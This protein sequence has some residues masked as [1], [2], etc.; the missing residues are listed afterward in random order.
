[1]SVA[2]VVVLVAAVMACVGAVLVL[3][4]AVVLVGAVRRL[5]RGV[6]A[7]RTEA[8]P[9]V[10]GARQA[11]DQA[12]DEMARVGAVLEST[13]SV[14]ATVDSV[15]RLAQRAF[16]NPVVKI[17][18]FRA[19]AATGLRQLRTPGPRV[20]EPPAHPRRHRRAG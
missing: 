14:T 9:L 6:E 3:V 5:E 1:M 19:G 17:L 15:S 10:T 8:V 11:V 2:D 16:T 4:A 7:L 13:E 18:A 20:V 12:T